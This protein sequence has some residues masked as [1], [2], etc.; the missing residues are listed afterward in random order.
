[1]RILVGFVAG[2]VLGIATHALFPDH[3]RVEQLVAN[4][5]EPLGKLFLRLLILTIVPLIFSSL[6][7][8]V[9]GLGDLRK[10][11]RVGVKTLAYTLIVSA[12]SV[13]IGLGMA[14]VV[15][16]GARLDEATR[17]SLMERYQTQA[18]DVAAKASKESKAPLMSVVEIVP[19]NPLA[20]AAKNPPDMLGLMFFSVFFGVALALVPA[21]RTRPLLTALEAVYEAAS[22]MIHL[23]MWA[24]PKGAAHIT[25]WIIV[26]AAS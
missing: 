4:V 18:L 23:V 17:A 12:I 25:R 19:D 8:G 20:S 15:K 24:T 13:V 1:M 10:L 6:V 26:D 21:D 16:P 2:A 9:T 7:L 5:T 11:G 14:N 3:P 22:T